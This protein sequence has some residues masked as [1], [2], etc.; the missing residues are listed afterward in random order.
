[1]L[2][3]IMYM[4][5]RGKDFNYTHTYR[6]RRAHVYIS[7]SMWGKLIQRCNEYRERYGD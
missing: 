3:I 4:C 1:M 6:C 7:A 5:M 2:T